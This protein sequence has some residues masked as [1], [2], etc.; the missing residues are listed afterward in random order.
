MLSE[1]LKM[2]LAYTSYAGLELGL[3]PG[4]PERRIVFIRYY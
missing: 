1:E 2:R 3:G 4:G